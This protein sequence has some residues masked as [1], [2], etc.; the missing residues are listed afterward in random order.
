MTINGLAARLNVYVE[1]GLS[2]GTIVQASRLFQKER[3][4][5]IHQSPGA[6][7]HWL[8]DWNRIIISTVS[9]SRINYV[10]QEEG[11]SDISKVPCYI[12]PINTKFFCYSVLITL[13]NLKAIFNKIPNSTNQPN[14]AQNALLQSYFLGCGRWCHLRS[15]RTFWGQQQLQ[16]LRSSQI[17]LSERMGWMWCMLLL[18]FT[19]AIAPWLSINF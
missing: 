11:R 18:C 17:R 2:S 3:L 16:A 10:I 9:F 4:A 12:L 6:R 19:T 7:L 15:R 1:A 13:I 14:P 8:G 5:Q